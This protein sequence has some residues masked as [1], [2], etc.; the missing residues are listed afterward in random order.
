MKTQTKTAGAIEREQRLA[1][2]QRPRNF[3]ASAKALPDALFAGDEEIQRLM[4]RIDR[5]AGAVS[6]RASLR[7]GTLLQEAMAVLRA[8]AQHARLAMQRAAV[9]DAA[10]G[11]FEFTR[12]VAVAEQAA[13]IQRQQEAAALSYEALVTRA[14]VDDALPNARRMLRDTLLSRKRAYLKAHPELLAPDGTLLP[15]PE[16]QDEEQEPLLDAEVQEPAAPE[17]AEQA[18]EAEPPA[19]GQPQ[20]GAADA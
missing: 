18:K 14:M 17:Q 16:A 4:Q 5:L 11:D 10:A 15:E 20:E 1:A 19:E 3:E 2:E 7:D 8:R 9:D 6:G 12:A 13:V